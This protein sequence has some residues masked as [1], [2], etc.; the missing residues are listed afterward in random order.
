MAGRVPVRRVAAGHADRA[1]AR[2]EGIKG[3]PP[4][5]RTAGPGAS[6]PAAGTGGAGASAA[7]ALAACARGACAGG[8]RAQRRPVRSRAV[9]A[10]TWLAAAALLGGC[11]SG[12]LTLVLRPAGPRP[13]PADAVTRRGALWLPLYPGAR[14]ARSAPGFA[15]VLARDTAYLLAGEAEFTVAAPMPSVER[16]YR[17]ALPAVGYVYSGAETLTDPGG[18]LRPTLT[19]RHGEYLAVEVEFGWQGAVETAVRYQAQQLTAPARPAPSYLR[20]IARRVDVAYYP[21]GLAAADRPPVRVRV[22]DRRLVARLVAA[23]NALQP[24]TTP[25]ACT[26]G[27]GVAILRFAQPDGRTRSVTVTPGCGTVSV[28]RY[29]PLDDPYGVVFGLAQ[30]AACGSRSP[31]R[32]DP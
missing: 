9:V 6:V 20:A 10:G 28:D 3:A 2:P 7:G 22:A 23:I 1:P 13:L 18:G 25:P 4:R 31:A 19:F 15:P 32:C 30:Q 24:Q 27:A 17:K 11:L 5:P 14:P 26:P 8:A 16:W 12:G 29:P 21:R